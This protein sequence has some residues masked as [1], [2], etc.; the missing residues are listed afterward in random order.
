M[1]EVSKDAFFAAMKADK[2]DIMP[3]IAGSRS[4][5]SGYTSEWRTNDNQRALFGKSIETPPTYWLN[6]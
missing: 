6:S 4:P 2:R 1:K 3:V 5:E